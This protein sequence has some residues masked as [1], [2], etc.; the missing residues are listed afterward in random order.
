MH[1]LHTLYTSSSRRYTLHTLHPAHCAH[2]AYP[3]HPRNVHSCKL[4]TYWLCIPCTLTQH[5]AHQ[6][7]LHIYTLH[8]AHPT[9][10]AHSV[11]P[12]CSTYPGACTVN[13]IHTLCSAHSVHQA[14]P[15]HHAINTLC[16]LYSS[17]CV[18]QG[19][20]QLIYKY[21]NFIQ[22]LLLRVRLVC[23]MS[24]VKCTDFAGTFCRLTGHWLQQ[25]Y[26]PCIYPVH[27]AYLVSYT[28]HSLPP[29]TFVHGAWCPHHCILN[30]THSTGIFTEEQ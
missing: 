16:T 28:L 12:T 30:S 6:A 4:C 23:L 17:H 9:D 2:P 21:W 24:E 13:N 7:H 1:T 8:P 29:L 27:P 18:K 22:V 15:V 20:V 14:H 25:L 5:P 10:S 3:V 11:H 26:T 19:W